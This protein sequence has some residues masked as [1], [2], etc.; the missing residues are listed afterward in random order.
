MPT[1]L[2]AEASNRGLR[3]IAGEI[4]ER[5]P[6]AADLMLLTTGNNGRAALDVFNRL[7][8]ETVTRDLPAVLLLDENHHDWTDEAAG[9][10]HRVVAKMPIKMREL[11]ELLVDVSEKKVS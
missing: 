9:A 3:R 10:E 6:Q 8:Q 4:L 7:G 1:L 5:H 2:D 11:R